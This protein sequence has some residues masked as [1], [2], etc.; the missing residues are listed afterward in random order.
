M[1]ALVEA[2]STAVSGGTRRAGAAWRETHAARELI[3]DAPDP[4]RQADRLEVREVARDPALLRGHAVRDEQDVCRGFGDPRAGARVVDRQGRAGV[5]AGDTK[6]WHPAFGGVRREL[7]D[8]RAR[9]E[10]EHRCSG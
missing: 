4:D 9:A 6:R 7:R 8:A 10:K 3:E 1:N 2:R 5:R